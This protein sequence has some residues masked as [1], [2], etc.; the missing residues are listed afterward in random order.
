[1]FLMN[2]LTLYMST[3]GQE[4]SDDVCLESNDC[5]WLPA[6]PGGE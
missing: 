2:Q 3:A 4:L 6:F 5:D 1:M